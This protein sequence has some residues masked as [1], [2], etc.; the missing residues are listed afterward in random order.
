MTDKT[1]EELTVELA[2]IKKA[3]LEIELTKEK[4]KEVKHQAELAAIAR[5]Q[6]EQEI[7]EKIKKELGYDKKS[8]LEEN[9]EKQSMNLTGN[10]EHEN[11]KANWV[12]TRELKDGVKVQGLSYLE[13]MESIVHGAYAKV[14]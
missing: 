13:L 5:E 8:K 3:N 7:T 14:K 4:E 12:K 11:F 10:K 2:A 6:L 1:V 9:T